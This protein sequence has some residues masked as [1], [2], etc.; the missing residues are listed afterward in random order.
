MLLFKMT[1]LLQMWFHV[2]ACSKYTEHLAPKISLHLAKRAS[3]LLLSS[4]EMKH[5][6][7][8]NRSKRVLSICPDVRLLQ[9]ITALI[10]HRTRLL[11]SGISPWK[12]QTWTFRVLQ[13]LPVAHRNPSL[14]LLHASFNIWNQEM[15]IWASSHETITGTLREQYSYKTCLLLIYS[16]PPPVPLTD[17][18]E[19]QAADRP[20]ERVEGHRTLP[21][22]PLPLDT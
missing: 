21:E 7:T 17:L 19:I 11:S 22:F 4:Q 6:S 1:F 9:L 10:T 13:W 2:L 12:G 18:N 20:T 14:S 15:D 16:L 5:Y 3:L 8:F